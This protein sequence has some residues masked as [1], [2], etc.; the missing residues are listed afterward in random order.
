[1]PNQ[2][3]RNY[4]TDANWLGRSDCKHCNIR[5]LMLFTGL[6]DSAF[7]DHLAPVDHF[8]FPAGSTLYREG[9]ND[10]AV[11]SIRRGIA[12]LLSL[13]SDGN[14]RIVRLHG[15]GM[16]AGLELL[17][18]GECYR[19]TALAATEIDACRIPVTTI[20]K[21]EIDFPEI[22]H[23][24]RLRL[25]NQLDRA[26]EWIMELGTGPARRRIAHLILMMMEF[27]TSP[28]QGITLLSGTD[29]GAI[30]GASPETVS[31]IMADMK[32]NGVL[33]KNSDSLYQGNT[34][35]LEGMLEE[36]GQ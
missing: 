2:H 26:D 15:P 4:C 28:G 34:P 9:D 10:G 6:P 25:Q 11:F 7:E 32:R 27:S 29:I 31:R 24:V 20:E 19:H 5:H 14:Q 23:Q 33:I 30:I 16:T 18:P 36:T 12:K 17:E 3:L 13:T 21:L 1:M 22:C 35:A 8:I